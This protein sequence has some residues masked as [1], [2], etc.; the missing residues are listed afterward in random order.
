MKRNGFIIPT[1]YDFGIEFAFNR[2]VITWATQGDHMTKATMTYPANR[3]SVLGV[4]ARTRGHSQP[5]RRSP[6]LTSPTG[7]ACILVAR[8]VVHRSRKTRVSLARD[9]DI[10]LMISFLFDIRDAMDGSFMKDETTRTEN[11]YPVFNIAAMAK[12][13]RRSHKRSPALTSPL[14]RA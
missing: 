6:A 2:P 1:V 8:G 11:H 13:R 7:R 3:Y 4:T 14:G 10:A 12:N 9:I 5:H